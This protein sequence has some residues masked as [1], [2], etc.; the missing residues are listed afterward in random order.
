VRGDDSSVDSPRQCYPHPRVNI[1]TPVLVETSAMFCFG[2]WRGTMATDNRM[3]SASVGELDALRRLR[4]VCQAPS[5]VL[6]PTLQG[7]KGLISRLTPV[8]NLAA[9]T[10]E[11]VVRCTF[12]PVQ[13]RILHC[14]VLYAPRPNRPWLRGVKLAKRS[15]IA[16]GILSAHRITI[17][18]VAD[19]GVLKL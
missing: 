15:R 3:C 12:V 13:Q 6:A 1:P 11:D 9:V 16:D 17:I 18:W 10:H 7:T 5:P 8:Q 19:P 4:Q 14:G 2:I